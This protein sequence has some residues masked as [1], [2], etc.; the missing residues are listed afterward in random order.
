MASQQFILA[1]D[2]IISEASS[3]RSTARAVAVSIAALIAS[4]SN[5][6]DD[7]YQLLEKVDEQMAS[8]SPPLKTLIYNRTQ[9]FIEEYDSNGAWNF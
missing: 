3:G 5:S 9:E 6:L 4:H 7:A 8:L 1:L 2:R